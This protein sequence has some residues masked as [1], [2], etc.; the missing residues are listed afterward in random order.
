MKRGEEEGV[1][2]ASEAGGMASAK[3]QTKYQR[4]VRLPALPRLPARLPP[5]IS[6]HLA[7]EDHRAR[8]GVWDTL[9]SSRQRVTRIELDV[10]GPHVDTPMHVVLSIDATCEDEDSVHSKNVPVKAT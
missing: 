5:K 7:G 9:G 3:K 10:R 8:L 2:F 4:L 1:D 6:V